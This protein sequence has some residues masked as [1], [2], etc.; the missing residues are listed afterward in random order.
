MCTIIYEALGTPDPLKLKYNS[1]YRDY[2]EHPK[3]NI[4]I[5]IERER[6]R[7][8]EISLAPIT[9]LMVLYIYIYIHIYIHIHIYSCEPVHIHAHSK[10]N[11]VRWYRVQCHR[12][13]QLRTMILKVISNCFGQWPP[14]NGLG[15]GCRTASAGVS[16]TAVR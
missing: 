9:E 7:E 16:E 3:I 6:E 8:R 15:S 2:P 12:A 5:Y 1:F 4:Y 11:R 14:P 13:L 10:Q